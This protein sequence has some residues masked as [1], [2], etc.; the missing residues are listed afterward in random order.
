MT[1][2]LITLLPEGCDG[3]SNEKYPIGQYEVNR[4]G[5][6]LGPDCSTTSRHWITQNIKVISRFIEIHQ[7]RIQ[8][9]KNEDFSSTDGMTVQTGNQKVTLLD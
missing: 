9:K 5:E 7:K 6:I 4:N 2:Q 1:I 8:E 3:W